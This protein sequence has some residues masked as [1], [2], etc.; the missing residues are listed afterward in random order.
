[1][2]LAQ[3]FLAL[4]V[5]NGGKVSSFKEIFSSVPQGA[6]F[7]PDFWDFDISEM[8]AFLSAFAMLIA[9][10]DDCGLWYPIT[11]QNRL[12][13]VNQINADLESLMVWARDNKTLFEPTKTHYT[14]IS[15]KT[16][17]KFDV[18]FPF[19]RIVFDGALV[20]R[21]KEVKLVGYTFDETMSWSG[22]I[23]AI[24]K[25]ARMRMGMLRKLRYVL[26]DRNMELMYTSFIRPIME[27]GCVQ[28]MGA[29]EVH[30]MKL[31]AVQKTAEKIG[32]FKVESLQSRRE[33][34]AVA[35]TLKLLDGA[36]RGV[37]KKHIPKI[38]TRKS[39]KDYDNRSGIRHLQIADRTNY[40]SLDLFKAGYLGQIHKIWARIPVSLLEKGQRIGWRKITKQCKEVITGKTSNK[41]KK[42]V[43]IKFAG[44]A[45]D[46]F[47]ID[48]FSK[49]RNCEFDDHRNDK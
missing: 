33:A 46:G 24:A 31:D 49:D 41:I 32:N 3:H 20:K 19:E 42:G 28:F 47:T 10:A 25:K 14:L 1:M 23:G 39:K 22:M 40:D 29:K 37:L 38:V 5:V 45:K 44:V 35:F 11:N 13:I 36:A 17:N 15:K 9:Y 18:C 27:Y 34:T 2:Q 8:E 12:F 26:D 21:K 4:Q 48:G 7:S 16:T 6:I 30:L 43:E